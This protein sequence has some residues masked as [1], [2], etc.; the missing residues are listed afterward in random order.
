LISQQLFEN[1]VEK[2]RDL[3]A[4]VSSSR[5]SRA[6]LS[7]VCDQVALNLSS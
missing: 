7:R 2:L 6:T 3:R 4:V 5:M 1:K